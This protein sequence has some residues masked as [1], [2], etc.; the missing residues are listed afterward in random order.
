M[1]SRHA[2][3]LIAIADH[4]GFTRAAAELHVSQPALSQQIRQL[5]ETLGAQ[6]LDRSGRTVRLTDA[7]RTYIEYARRA[8]REFD[9]GR[10]AVRDVE[11][12]E[13]GMLRL[14]FTPTFSTYLIGPLT[15]LFNRRHPGVAVS[16][17]VVPQADVESGLAA[18]RLDVGIA[19]GRIQSAEIVA[20]PLFEEQLC[21][22]VGRD[23]DGAGPVE[24]P[25]SALDGIGLALLNTAF[26]TRASIDFYLRSNGVHPRVV[27]ESNSVDTL[28][29]IVRGGPLATILPED[30]VRNVNGLTAIRLQPPIASRTVSL[31]LREGGYRSA[32]TR[33]FIRVSA[34]F[35]RARLCDDTS[36]AA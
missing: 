11:N 17:D 10:R 5:E 26:A 14:A 7:G 15:Q 3:Y 4:G 34:D 6:L 8:L 30:S 20:Q 22:I 13:G 9:A 24:L 19:F 18:D 36:D 2:R 28:V 27:V 31:L 25:V 32:A 12:L 29:A 21:L 23:P 16:I 35:N 1:I 33:A